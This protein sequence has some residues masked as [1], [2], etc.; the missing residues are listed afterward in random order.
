MAVHMV[1][2]LP[3][4]QRRAPGFS[5]PTQGKQGRPAWSKSSSDDLAYTSV[6]VHSGSFQVPQ[7]PSQL[8][9]A[10]PSPEAGAPFSAL[11]F[12][13]IGARTTAG[14][15]GPAVHGAATAT[16]LIAPAASVAATGVTFPTGPAPSPTAPMVWMQIP[17]V[18]VAGMAVAM[19]MASTQGV[20]MPQ[21]IPML[22]GRTGGENQSAIHPELSRGSALHAIGKC[23]PCA[24]FWKQGRGCQSGAYCEYCH[25]CPEGELK[26][27][28]KA[29][30]K[31]MRMS[32]L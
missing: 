22:L 8:W 29:K 32:G 1:E 27:R 17:Q 5:P 25:L 12:G 23:Q 4:N 9:P 31:A 13:S 11:A 28:K 30:V 6:K 21:Q 20:H 24:W 14:L 3:L 19:N 15:T 10:T 7:T 2:P 16:A 26:N 18:P